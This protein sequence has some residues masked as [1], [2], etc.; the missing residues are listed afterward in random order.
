MKAD[1][2]EDIDDKNPFRMPWQHCI[3][4]Q[5]P[6]EPQLLFDMQKARLHHTY[7][8]SQRALIGQILT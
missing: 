7:T 8:N 1:K 6:L 3:D 2:R 4:F 5:N